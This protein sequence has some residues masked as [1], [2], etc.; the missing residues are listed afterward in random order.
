MFSEAE[1]DRAH[2][3]C[4]QHREEVLASERAGCF[5]CLATFAPTEIADWCDGGQTA[6]CP[7]CGIDSVVGSESGFP[8]TGEFLSAMKTRWF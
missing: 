1:L 3:R 4:S 8:I 2:G 6:L 7:R 5:F